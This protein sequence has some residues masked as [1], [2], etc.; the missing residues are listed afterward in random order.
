MKIRTAKKRIHRNVEWFAKHKIPL[1]FKYCKL[2]GAMMRYDIGMKYCPECGHYPDIQKYR[3]GDG[4][5]AICPKCSRR[6]VP[7]PDS[8][9]AIAAWNDDKL[10]TVSEMLS[11][12][13]YEEK[14]GERN[15]GSEKVRRG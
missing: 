5:I 13:L 10:T 7:Q 6:T 4:L 12:P 14:R 9:A 1:A 3:W 11:H 15:D 2:K 8:L